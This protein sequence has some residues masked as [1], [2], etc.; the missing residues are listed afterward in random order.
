MAAAAVAP[1]AAVSCSR[2]RT[3]VQQLGALAAACAAAAAAAALMS[4]AAAAEAAAVMRYRR[5]GVRG[6]AAHTQEHAW[7]V[8]LPSPPSAYPTSAYPTRRTPSRRRHLHWY[9]RWSI[10]RERAACAARLASG[11]TRCALTLRPHRSCLPFA[12]VAV[13]GCTRPRS[14]GMHPIAMWDASRAPPRRR[15]R[16][17]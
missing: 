12:V 16:I 11:C 6:A 5:L 3:R 10:A 14:G 1:A 8:S 7:H 2:E 13:P 15:P 4:T 9:T 17:M